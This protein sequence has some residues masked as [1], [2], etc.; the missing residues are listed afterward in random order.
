MARDSTVLNPGVGGDAIVDEKIAQPD[1]T[2]LRMPISKIAIGEEGIDRGNVTADN[3]L[4]VS[5]ARIE[6]LLEE[7]NLLLRELVE[8]L[9]SD[10][11]R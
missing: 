5:A 7:Q 8:F 2:V 11:G 10:R 1:G 6:T 3:P 9:Q 4:P